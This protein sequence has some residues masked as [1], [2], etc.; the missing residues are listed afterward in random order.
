M[1]HIAV[2]VGVGAAVTHL[3]GWNWKAGAL[4]GMTIS[5]ASTVVLTRVLTDNRALHTTTGHVALGWLD[6]DPSRAKATGR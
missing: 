5:V 2:S 1:V 4:F 6:G 3:F